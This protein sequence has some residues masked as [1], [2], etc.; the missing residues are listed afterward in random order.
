M[1]EITNYDRLCDVVARMEKLNDKLEL[2]VDM[3][4]ANDYQELFNDEDKRKFFEKVFNN[5]DHASFFECCSDEEEI[6]F[7]CMLI[8]HKTKIVG[9]AMCMVYEA[10]MPLKRY[11]SWV[12]YIATHGAPQDV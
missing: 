12:D 2:F 4:I 11:K 5:P 3:T 6:L 8:A 7:A 9:D 1:R 10:L